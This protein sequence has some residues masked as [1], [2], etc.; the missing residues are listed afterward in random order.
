MGCVHHDLHSILGQPSQPPPLPQK[1]NDSL[2]D[3]SDWASD[4]TSCLT[5]NTG[6]IEMLHDTTW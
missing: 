4:Q 1:E 3:K 5:E 6:A 2:E